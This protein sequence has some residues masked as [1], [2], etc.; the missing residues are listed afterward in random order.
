MTNYSPGNNATAL[1]SQDLIDQLPASLQ[2]KLGGADKANLAEAITRALDED[3]DALIGAYGLLWRD[4]PGSQTSHAAR[5]VLIPRL[6]KSEQE[7]GIN[8]A[9]QKFGPEEIIF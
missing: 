9:L 8:E 5:A 4:V 1:R 6:S 7:R 3:R 2:E